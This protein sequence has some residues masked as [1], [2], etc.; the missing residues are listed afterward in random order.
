[1]KMNARLKQVPAVEY[2]DNILSSAAGRTA[3]LIGITAGTVS[4]KEIERAVL[5][6]NEKRPYRK[7][8][9]A[10]GKRFDSVRSAATSQLANEL[11]GAR[12][13]PTY[14]RM[15]NAEEKRIAYYCNKDDTVGFYWSE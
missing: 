11:V 14:A 15:L 8:V 6:D 13:G 2:E 3:L 9:V 7:P 1:M 5:R 10:Y 12:S 4:Q